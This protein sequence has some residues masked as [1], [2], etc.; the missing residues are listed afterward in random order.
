GG[1]VIL[2]AQGREAIFRGV[3]VGVE[4]WANDGRPWHPDL[5]ADGKCPSAQDS[6][7]QPPACA[8]NFQKVPKWEQNT[9]Y[10]SRNDLAQVRSL[11]GFNLIRMAISWSL[12]EP[13]A[14]VISE[15]YF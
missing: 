4:E 8:V 10:T 13:K 12:L 1:H 9:I 3:N 2:D 15:D 14:G 11:L 7:N 6:K 5:Y